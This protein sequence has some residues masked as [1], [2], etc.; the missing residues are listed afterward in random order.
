MGSSQNWGPK[1]LYGYIGAII[2]GI[3]GKKKEATI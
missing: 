2:K 3:A 1:I